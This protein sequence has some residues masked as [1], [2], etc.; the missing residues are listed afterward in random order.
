MVI[1]ATSLCMSWSLLEA[2]FVSIFTKLTVKKAVQKKYCQDKQE[3][4]ILYLMCKVQ[5]GFLVKYL[6]RWVTLSTTW[7]PWVPE[8]ENVF[9][10]LKAATYT[11]VCLW[12]LRPELCLHEEGACSSSTAALRHDVYR[13]KKQA[14]CFYRAH[15][16]IY[17]RAT[18][19]AYKGL[20]FP[21][22]IAG[23][24]SFISNLFNCR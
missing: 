22:W 16:M 3:S 23:Q 11:H 24:R 4:C 14:E 7:Y 10:S 17:V 8:A 21:S 6:V 1:R 19:R 13:R 12:E 15:Q 5:L 2:Y 18:S 9:P 20:G